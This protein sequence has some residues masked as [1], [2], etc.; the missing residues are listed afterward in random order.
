MKS[1]NK[2]LGSADRLIQSSEFYD[3]KTATIEEVY[4]GY[5]ASLGATV[6]MS[7]LVPTL[8]FYIED[9]KR[10]KVMDVVARLA[11][12]NAG[13]TALL[14]LYKAEQNRDVLRMATERIVNAS[15]ALKIMMRT[16]KF[17]APN[18]DD[19]E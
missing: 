14:N 4:K 18:D 13:A 7:G 9:P 10:K 17:V 16:Y 5:V 19:D 8:A 6:I 3:R 12:E 2:L 11:G 15:I 1:V